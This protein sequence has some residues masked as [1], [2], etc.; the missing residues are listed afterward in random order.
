MGHNY[1]VAV[2]VAFKEVNSQTEMAWIFL[3]LKKEVRLICDSLDEKVL[4]PKKSEFLKIT[5]SL[6]YKNHLEVNFS[7]RHYCFPKNEVVLLDA[8]NITTESLARV[9]YQKLKPTLL[10]SPNPLS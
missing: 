5:E 10:V 7:D 3:K 9:I 6:N 1:Q 2:K 4:M 8:A